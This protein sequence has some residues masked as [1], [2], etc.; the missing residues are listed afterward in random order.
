MG[1]LKGSR[2]VMGEHAAPLCMRQMTNLQSSEDEV[3]LRKP[4]VPLARAVVGT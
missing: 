1:G 2:V 3:E 4:H